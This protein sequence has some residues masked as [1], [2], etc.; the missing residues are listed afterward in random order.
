[1]CRL[2]YCKINY[3]EIGATTR[4]YNHNTLKDDEYGL[5]GS[6]L[7]ISMPDDVR[8]EIEKARFLDCVRSFLYC[9]FQ[10]L[11]IFL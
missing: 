7:R 2:D 9:F 11:T 8:T 6:M 3:H 10:Q 4:I 5:K 1:M